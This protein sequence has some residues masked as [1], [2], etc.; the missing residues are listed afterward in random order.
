MKKC[1]LIFL[2]V[3]I[4]IIYAGNYRFE[5]R[6][7][8]FNS[9]F[10][11]KKHT[12]SYIKAPHAS[13]GWNT[14]DWGIL[15]T[16]ELYVEPEA[17]I[18]LSSF[19]TIN[20]ISEW[21]HWD[22]WLKHTYDENFFGSYSRYVYMITNEGKLTEYIAFMKEDDVSPW[23]YWDKYVF[24]YKANGKILTETN[25]G[26]ND[27]DSTWVDFFKRSY[28]YNTS[29]T[30]TEAIFY[31]VDSN[32]NWIESEKSMYSYNSTPAMNGI[33]LLEK[34]SNDWIEYGK[35]IINYGTNGKITELIYY[36]Y[37][38][39]YGDKTTFMYNTS[40][41]ITGYTAS[42]LNVGDSTWLPDYNVSMSYD[43]NGD[44]GEVITQVMDTVKS[45]WINSNNFFYSYDENKN[46]SEETVLSWSDEVV[47]WVNSTKTS[48]TYNTRNNPDK[49]LNYE[50]NES[51][52]QWDQVDYTETIT[53]EY[54]NSIIPD[55][56]TGYLNPLM[57]VTNRNRNLQ[58]SLKG[59]F[60]KNDAMKVYDL[61]GR[62]ICSMKPLW[63][64]NKSV[65]TWD[66][67]DKNNKTASPQ[68][69]LLAVRNNEKLLTQ[70]IVLSR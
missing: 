61:H 6:G 10:K 68:V 67:S 34:I 54:T 52:Q 53:Y 42:L 63:V 44:Y 29:G 38:K 5:K 39:E 8:F 25:Q 20:D 11:N 58:V 62:L 15:W 19:L 50:W 21:G 40:N 4:Q 30:L 69:Y 9:L 41:K 1:A 35:G 56:F 18:E 24:E 43:P 46:M 45:T 17:F 55:N 16:L 59:R 27:L 7:K 2:I 28:V 37:E 65:Y 33:S 48:Y 12:R 26:W 23:E 13:S 47:D 22:G 66:I 36:E 60:G 64:N 70:K 32:N 31:D 51:T 14:Y 49:A 57:Q 3:L